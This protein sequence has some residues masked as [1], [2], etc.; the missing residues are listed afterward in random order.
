[1]FHK[2]RNR[3]LIMMASRCRFICRLR[4]DDHIFWILNPTGCFVPLNSSESQRSA[5]ARVAVARVWHVNVPF[6][7]KR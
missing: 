2:K 7:V 6:G 1:M 3:P 5:A 4:G